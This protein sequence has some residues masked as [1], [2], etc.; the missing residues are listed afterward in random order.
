V[1]VK[2]RELR[3]RPQRGLRAT[4]QRQDGGGGIHY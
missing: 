1:E 3:K 2:V 4:M